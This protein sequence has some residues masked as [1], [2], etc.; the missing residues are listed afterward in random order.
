MVLVSAAAVSSFFLATAA[1]FR[2]FTDPTTTRRPFRPA[3]P[4]NLRFGAPPPAPTVDHLDEEASNHN[5]IP[6]SS[7]TLISSNGHQH[8]HHTVGHHDGN[9]FPSRLDNIDMDR[10]LTNRRL[11]HNYVGC[12]VNQKPCTAEGKEFKRSL[13]DVLL[14]ECSKCSVQMQ[15]NIEH[16]VHVLQKEYPLEWKQLVKHYDPDGS[17]RKRYTQYLLHI[18]GQEESR[19]TTTPA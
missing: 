12:M 1:F 14:T 3:V 9:L 17:Y 11:V 6:S 16:M 10:I 15:R 19:S 8:I 18:D 7:D 4:L 5:T 13:P 2:G